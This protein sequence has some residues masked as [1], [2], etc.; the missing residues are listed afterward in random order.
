MGLSTYP[1]VMTA[2]LAERVYVVG[3]VGD[4]A[5]GFVGERLEEYGVVTEPLDRDRL[6]TYDAFEG[7][8]DLLMLLGSARSGAST[9]Q[10]DVVAAESAL[11]CAALDNGVPVLGICYGSQ[12]LAHALGGSIKPSPQP[13]IE[14]VDVPSNDP[15][16][17]PPGPWVLMH[18]DTFDPPPTARVFGDTPGGC[19]GFADESRGARALAWQFHP[20]VTPQQL[21]KWLV[22][23]ADWVAEHGGDAE[24]VRSR[25]YALE[26]DL[27]ERAY[28]LTDTAL[29]WLV[30]R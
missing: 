19:I 17:C 11:V 26:D 21:D 30:D 24:S 22:S 3:D 25:G 7:G 1:E 12:L 28:A 27:R 15:V 8:P 9:D 14:I 16:L 23:M 2:N 4:D 6:P 13:E 10:A 20:E 18:S 29:A 5:Q